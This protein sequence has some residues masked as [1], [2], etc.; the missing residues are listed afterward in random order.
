MKEKKR[1]KRKPMP[2][3][4]ADVPES[5]ESLESSYIHHA[6]Y[7]KGTETLTIAFNSR[8]GEGPTYIYPGV[9]ADV[10]AEFFMAPSKGKHFLGRI[11][12]FFTGQIQ[13]F[14]Q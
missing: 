6:I 7:D 13:E 8:G 4:V 9:P 14:N 10:W 12:P 2:A 11:K 3:V 1:S 5:F